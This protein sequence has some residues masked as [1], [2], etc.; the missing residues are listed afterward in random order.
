MSPAL[1]AVFVIFAL[2]PTRGLGQRQAN[3]PAPTFRVA[4]RVTDFSAAAI[5][6]ASVT[7]SAPQGQIT[8]TLT[9]ADGRFVL[10]VDP[11]QAYELRFESPGFSKKTIPGPR[12][13]GKSE[14]DIGTVSLEIGRGDGRTVYE[15]TPLC[16]LV[17]VPVRFNEKFVAVR[18]MVAASLEET[19]LVDEGCSARILL[20]TADPTAPRRRQYE[21]S[22][23]GLWPISL[24]KGDQFKTL[25]ELL[26]KDGTRVSA[27]IM[28]RFDHLDQG[29]FGNLGLWNSQLVVESVQDVQNMP[30]DSRVKK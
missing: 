6:N 24:L 23:P 18:A 4:G 14:V 10:T 20:E 11:S 5:A 13:A 21:S 25:N 15:M 16:E 7:A 12:P 1:R 30:A 22:H 17:K 9:A 27:T 19:F 8:W 2:L 28:G 26:R 3:T 29:G